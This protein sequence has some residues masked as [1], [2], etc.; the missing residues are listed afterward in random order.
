M[1]Y[2]M[3]LTTMQENMARYFNYMLEYMAE[4]KFLCPLEDTMACD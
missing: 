1:E 3:Y 2:Y 4:S